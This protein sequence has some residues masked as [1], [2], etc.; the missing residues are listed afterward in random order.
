MKTKT[1]LATVSAAAL[2]A[3]SGIGAASATTL[4]AEPKV[5]EPAVDI[6]QDPAAVSAPE[7]AGKRAPKTHNVVLTTTEVEARLDDGTTYTYWT[8]NNK[9]PGPMVRVRVG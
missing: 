3:L 7:A 6:V 8:F 2:I 9:V 5:K 4:Y 1:F